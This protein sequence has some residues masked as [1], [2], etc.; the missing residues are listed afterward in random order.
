MAKVLTVKDILE[1]RLPFRRAK[2]GTS[3]TVAMGS[4][5]TTG[6]H[7]F[8]V[9]E[10]R[11]ER[12]DMSWEYY[13]ENQFARP[14][15]NL[16]A[17][18][19]FGKGIII[20]G[21]DDQVVWA[22]SFL[23]QVDLFQVGIES[24]IYGDNFFRIF[25]DKELENKFYLAMLPPKTID[26]KNVDGENVADVKDY[27]QMYGNDAGTKKVI[28][29]SEMVHVMVN[30][31]SNSKFGNSDLHQLY[32]WL[33]MYDSVTEE[34][35]KRRM[36][37]SQPIGVFTGVDTRYRA[38]LKSRIAS[39][40]RDRDQK[41]GLRRSLPPG[42]QMF[43]P[44][45]MDYHFEEP[46]G[47]FDLEAMLNRIAIVIATAA[48]TPLHF[49][50]L[51]EKMALKVANVSMFPFTKK[52]Q[53]R[54]E[55]F[56]GKFEEILYKAYLLS[57]GVEKSGPLPWEGNNK[58]FDLQ[59]SFP[60]I[61]D[62]ELAEIEKMNKSI[63]SI[64]Q[65]KLIS[66]KTALDMVCKYFGLDVEKEEERLGTEKEEEPEESFS[67]M[68]IA[69]GEIGSAVANGEITKEVGTRI[70]NKLLEKCN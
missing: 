17:S 26:Q 31:V 11:K 50:N 63:V 13:L 53:R 49:L 37:A 67:P 12:Y 36:F 61:F 66:R 1:G 29:A 35:D 70:I 57:V 39:V 22:R 19:T 56:S 54:Q 33:D 20:T 24:G 69:I 43:L 6:K 48:E 47:K 21:D 25:S 2:Y 16:A 34:A 14:V 30:A 18:A 46:E 52:I 62:Y 9:P 8:K 41:V 59:V 15:I 3:V 5:E 51:A 65:L 58:E 28:P 42:S 64:W 32:Y 38:A 40:T 7:E 55:I 68:E 60:P 4:W 45:G 44:K 23:G 27:V 10:E